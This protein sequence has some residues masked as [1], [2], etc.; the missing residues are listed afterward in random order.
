VEQVNVELP[1][2]T[3]DTSTVGTV[4]T[5]FP[6]ANPGGFPINTDPQTQYSFGWGVNFCDAVTISGLPNGSIFTVSDVSL[7]SEGSSSQSAV[8]LLEEFLGFV[9]GWTSPTDITTVQ[10]FLFVEAD[11][12]VLDIPA[13]C[14][15]TPTS[16]STPPTWTYYT[17]AQLVTIASYFCGLTASTLPDPSDGYHGSGLPGLLLAGSESIYKWD[18]H[19]FVDWVDMPLPQVAIPAQDLWDEVQIYPG[20]GLVWTQAGSFGVST[21]LRVS[22]SLR[23]QATVLVYDSSGAALGGL[24]VKTYKTATQ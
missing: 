23:G 7:V 9:T 4:Q 10:P 24:Q 15:V 8:T 19:Q 16:G 6:I 5:R 12:K 1:C 20:A 13:L 11:G 2:G 18:T 14:L 21:P 3:G 22:K 17:L